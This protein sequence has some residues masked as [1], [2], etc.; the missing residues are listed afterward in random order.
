MGR[1]SALSAVP[2]KGTCVPWLL[3]QCRIHFRA[4]RQWERIQLHKNSGDH[5]VGQVEPQMRPA[6]PPRW[7]AARPPSAERMPRAGSLPP[8]EALR[9]TA[10]NSMAGCRLSSAA[11]LI[12]LYAL[13]ANFYLPVGASAEFDLPIRPAPAAIAGA[14][15]A[16]ALLR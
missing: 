13:A 15:H 10:A 6:V 2:S 11:Y 4:G 9:L 14:V 3:H 12:K 16:F 8:S 7:E 1:A 5:V